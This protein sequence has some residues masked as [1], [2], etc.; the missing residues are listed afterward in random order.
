MA[1]LI[2]VGGAIVVVVA[3]AAWYDHRARRRGDQVTVTLKRPW[4]G[5]M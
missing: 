1:F 3:L 5:R 2:V 4:R